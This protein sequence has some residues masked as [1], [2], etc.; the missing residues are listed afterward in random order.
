MF[1]KFLKRRSLLDELFEA[2]YD[3]GLTDVSKD[4]AKKMNFVF[5]E[6]KYQK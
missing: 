1:N 3:P 4:E 5:K 2:S 6:F